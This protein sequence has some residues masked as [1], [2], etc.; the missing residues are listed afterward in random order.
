LFEF[1]SRDLQLESWIHGSAGWVSSYVECMCGYFD[2]LGFD[3]RG[4][5]PWVERGFLSA[6]EAALV[7]D[8]HAKAD[9]YEEPWSARY[10]GGHRYVLED[11]AWQGV[12]DAARL[13]WVALSDRITDPEE[14]A[15]IA[16]LDAGCWHGVH[17]S[18]GS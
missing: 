13:A 14:R 8:F 12:V 9:A 4:Y 11:P 15:Q 1:S 16:A 10:E 5:A 6:E 3:E 17:P 2:D 18:R 7:Q